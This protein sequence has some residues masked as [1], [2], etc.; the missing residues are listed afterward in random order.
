MKKNI[1]YFFLM[2][3]LLLLCGCGEIEI[4]TAKE[5]NRFQKEIVAGIEPQN[6]NVCR[7]ETDFLNASS[8]IYH[9]V[10]IKKD[11]DNKEYTQSI[12][13]D[14][15]IEDKE[16][17]PINF[18]MENLLCVKILDNEK[19]IWI[20][21]NGDIAIT[22]KN[23]EIVNQKNILNI[24]EN[25]NIHLDE[26][27]YY[28]L[29]SLCCDNQY[30]YIIGELTLGNSPVRFNCVT[31][32]ELNVLAVDTEKIVA[33][34]EESKEVVLLS[35]NKDN[36]EICVYDE[37]AGEIKKTK[38]HSSKTTEL[39]SYYNRN[40]IGDTKFD[41]YIAFD[42]SEQ[43]VFSPNLC[44]IKKGKI[45][46]VFSYE[47]MGIDFS[48]IKYIASDN[49]EGFIICLQGSNSKNLQLI[50]LK[51]S[52]N[53]MNYSLK[54]QKQVLTIGIADY[55][56]E[57]EPYIAGFNMESDKFY[58][59]VK[60]YIKEYGDYNDAVTHLNMDIIA[61]K[62]C[63]AY[64]LNGLDVESYSEKGALLELKDYFDHRNKEG[65]EDFTDTFYRL[66]TNQDGKIYY[67]IPCYKLMGLG[68][69]EKIDFSDLSN[70]D[71]MLNENY[72]FS[73]DDTRVLLKRIIRYSGDRYIDIRNKKSNI[74]GEEFRSLLELLK[75]QN[76]WN[77]K[78]QE[79]MDRFC[80]NETYCVDVHIL[81]PQWFF[82]FE[83]FLG[84]DF[85]ALYPGGD[86]LCI[87]PMTFILGISSSCENPEGIY[88]FWD[89]IF[90]TA[91]YRKNFSYEGFPVLE[92][93]WEEK[94][95]EL[96]AT[97][98]YY[99]CDGNLWEPYDIRLGSGQSEFVLKAGSISS[100]D[101]E[102]MRKK[103]E[104]AIYVKPMPD[105]YV[106]IIIEEALE[107][108][109]GKKSLE[110]TLY[111]IDNRVNIALSE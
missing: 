87:D 35:R 51:P 60:D 13:F 61:G 81:Y 98:R 66:V 45:Y 9:E 54:N 20:N 68:G 92:S 83:E 103:A 7:L 65:L 79:D 104:E 89:Y 10:Y 2:Y 5:Y 94:K 71:A 46:N 86:G 80:N 58:I 93:I 105:K 12:F 76:D 67:I 39:Y 55:W 40:L 30:I 17:I 96:L 36:Y 100:E 102:R 88:E 44:G 4:K 64:F 107:Y 72:V 90:S 42:P 3:L 29:T 111:T 14:Y 11:K 106:D 28:S 34:Y 82:Y 74:M 6:E 21:W 91:V 27:T 16:I 25:N 56:T 32:Q 50:S 69:K 1:R 15:E 41:R 8:L 23:G 53:E 62:A 63:D 52:E 73:N 43:G 22:E 95:K 78:S 85:E 84:Q 97:E 33:A 109:D 47:K 26:H 110:E 77:H 57:Y 19:I 31:D 101:F 49:R 24:A 59:E 108:V 18:Q 99:D 75:K 38:G 70:I 48:N 37:N